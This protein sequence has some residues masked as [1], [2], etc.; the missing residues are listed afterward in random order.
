MLFAVAKR[1]IIIFFMCLELQNA[2]VLF[3]VFPV[4]SRSLELHWTV[5]DTN[6]YT[7]EIF[8]YQICYKKSNVHNNVNCS[9][10]SV[11]GNLTKATVSGL[12]PFQEYRVAIRGVVALGYGPYSNVLMSTTPESGNSG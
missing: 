1:E 3:N 11:A 2:P 9:L 12:H 6:E 7:G 10:Q 8:Y 4:S 5:P